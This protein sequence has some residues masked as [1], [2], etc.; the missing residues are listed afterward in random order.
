MERN[1]QRVPLKPREQILRSRRGT[2]SH[3]YNPAMIW[4]KRQRQRNPEN[5]YAMVFVYSGC[6]KAEAEKDQ[7][8][9]S[10]ALMGLASELF[11]YPVG[12]G[13]SFLIP[14]TVLTYSAEGMSQLSQNLHRCF[15]NHL[16]RGKFKNE[17]RPVLVNS[18]EA[19]YLILRGRA[20][21]AWKGSR[22]TWH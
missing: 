1:F 13:E 2:S 8:N 16:C 14:E 19:D 15:R 4:R 9:Q 10:R 21:K 3:Q 7:F 20:F 5:C 22:E 18:W 17:V 6:F 11:S 12:P